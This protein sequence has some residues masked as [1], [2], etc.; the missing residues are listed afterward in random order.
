VLKAGA[1]KG[2]ENPTVPVEPQCYR[3]AL[4]GS[5]AG[6]LACRDER[7]DFLYMNLDKI[8]EKMSRL[9]TSDFPAELYK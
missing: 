5:P 4:A 7:Q 3:S 9:T 6:L 1:M 2:T 8:S